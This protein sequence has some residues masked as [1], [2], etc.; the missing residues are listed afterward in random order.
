MIISAVSV[1]F[2]VVLIR[3][4]SAMCIAHSV[5]FFKKITMHLFGKQ[6]KPTVWVF[7][8]YCLNYLLINLIVLIIINNCLNYCLNCCFNDV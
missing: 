3:L 1:F 6:Y 2:Y 8:I 7:D 5:M 4:V